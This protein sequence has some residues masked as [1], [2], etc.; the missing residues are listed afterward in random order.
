MDS[1]L[2]LYPVQRTFLSRS[3]Q[4]VV[5]FDVPHLRCH[6]I[7]ADV[8]RVALSDNFVL[9]KFFTEWLLFSE[10]L[11]EYAGHFPIHTH[12]ILYSIK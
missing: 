9:M 6:E 7:C 10:F 8:H 1:S 11:R 2:A 3:E 12:V 5:F 4:I